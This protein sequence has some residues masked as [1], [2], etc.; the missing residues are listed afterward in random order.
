MDTGKEAEIKMNE[1]Q[2][3]VTNLIK[4]VQQL[5]VK[6]GDGMMLHEI[7]ISLTTY[8]NSLLTLG[9]KSAIAEEVRLS[10]EVK[11]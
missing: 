3:R 8:S 9:L 5:C 2:F 6:H 10:K 4:E 1:S 11:K 7:V